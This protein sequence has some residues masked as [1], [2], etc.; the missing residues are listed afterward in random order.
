MATIL[1][2]K[3]PKKAKVSASYSDTIISSSTDDLMLII[4]HALHGT[5]QD[6]RPKNLEL[7]AQL[8]DELSHHIKNNDESEHLILSRQSSRAVVE[9]YPEMQAKVTYTGN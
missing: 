1:E 7:A 3:L 8:L 2:F 6:C 9:R 5:N 4:H